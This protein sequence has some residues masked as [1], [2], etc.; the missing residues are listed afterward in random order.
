MLILGTGEDFGLSFT[1]MDAFIWDLKCTMMCRDTVMAN[2]ENMNERRGWSFTQDDRF[3]MHEQSG[4]AEKT[5]RRQLDLLTEMLAFA[6]ASGG[7]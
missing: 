7:A 6:W 5:G 4:M 1:E 2:V 3:K